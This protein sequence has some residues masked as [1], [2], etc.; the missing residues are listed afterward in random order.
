M[1]LGQS[2]NESHGV[3]K[4]AGQQSNTSRQK[5]GE[6]GL[7]IEGSPSSTELCHRESSIE[8]SQDCSDWGS[9]RPLPSNRN[10]WLYF[11]EESRDA[12]LYGDLNRLG[13]VNSKRRVSLERLFGMSIMSDGFNPNCYDPATFLTEFE[14]ARLFRAEQT[15]LI[16][17][18][19]NGNEISLPSKVRGTSG[20]AKKLHH[21]IDNLS[22]YIDANG[23][24]CSFLTLSAWAPVGLDPYELEV[25][26]DGMVNRLISFLKSLDGLNPRPID[27]FYVKEPTKR[28]YTHFHIFFVNRAYVAPLNVLG[29]WWAKQSMGDVRGVEVQMVKRGDS[30]RGIYYCLKYLLK[31]ERD[32]SWFGMQSLRGGRIFSVGHNL[33]HRLERWLASVS[34]SS[35]GE[36]VKSGTNSKYHFVSCQ[37][38]NENRP[39]SR[40]ISLLNG[41]SNESMILKS[42]K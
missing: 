28:G 21:F 6:D 38:V 5:S 24:E 17:C 2:A 36:L 10:G 41:G 18:D 23:L 9:L 25:R 19:D 14:K 40:R 8:N 42:I 22:D 7:V 29:D 16:L 33:K 39:F 15:R 12:L 35:V 27:Y 4:F 32:L 1:P 20:Y 13:Y 31:P 37:I 3:A 34:S 30:H 11:S 26:W